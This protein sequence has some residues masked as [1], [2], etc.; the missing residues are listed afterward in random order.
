MIVL[1]VAGSVAAA[2]VG[3]LAA[4]RAVRHRAEEMLGRGIADVERGISERLGGTARIELDG[5]PIPVLMALRDERIPAG[6]LTV[7]RAC[8]PNG[9]VVRLAELTSRGDVDA[10]DL[11]A[12]ITPRA[13]SRQLDVTGLSVRVSRGRLRLV[14][15]LASLAVDVSVV[16]GRVV[17]RIPAAPPPIGSVLSSGLTELVPRP[18]DGVEL[19]RVQVVDDEL[20]VRAI[21]DVR[22]LMALADVTDLRRP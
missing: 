6:R 11:V 14:V 1:W 17:L 7:E 18:P 16:D 15:G 9:L 12:R 5:D 13:I 2:G 8:L 10:A 3:A 19:H 22:A 20:E 21:V 4:R